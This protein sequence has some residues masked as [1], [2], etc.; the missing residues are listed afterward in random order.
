MWRRLLR[1]DTYQSSFCLRQARLA[2]NR[3]R[4]GWALVLCSIACIPIAPVARRLA[5][6]CECEQSEP[7]HAA[8]RCILL[9]FALRAKQATISRR[10]HSL[11][12]SCRRILR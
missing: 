3:P 7:G 6:E 8:A 5:R 11:T 4:M 9:L 2:L 1:V 12:L 10:L